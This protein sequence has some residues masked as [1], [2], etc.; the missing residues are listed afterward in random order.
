MAISQ[1][2]TPPTTLHLIGNGFD[3]FH[4][5]DSRYSDFQ[6]W[7]SDNNCYPL[8]TFIEDLCNN[9]EL[10]SNFEQALGK[11]DP[12]S[13]LKD[14]FEEFE[15]N[16]KDNEGDFN[17]GNL[18]STISSDLFCNL[19][20]NYSKLMQ[21]FKDWAKSIDIDNIETTDL[22]K[23]FGID[24]YGAFVTFNYTHTLEN[25]YKI[26]NVFH[27]HGGV[28]K[29][30]GEILVGHGKDFIET[31]NKLEEY[32]DNELFCVSDIRDGIIDLL[33]IGRKSVDNTLKSLEQY[34]SD[35]FGVQPIE[36]I[37]VI[38]HSYG[39]VDMPYFNYLKQQY[40]NATWLL[41]YH[42][43]DTLAK[44]QK[45]ANGIQSYQLKQI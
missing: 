12:V 1:T 29:Q 19:I 27:I 35:N 2:H 14:K 25:A 9:S 13:V 23:E 11:I 20:P 41:Y 33:N 22:S 18:S 26:S 4:C 6:N 37:I 15:E 8:I 42:D 16:G 39:E 44:A 38:G 34:I 7:L 5:I 21:A 43:K 36:K 28:K 17:P 31:R 30:D 45:F 3:L 32:L 10:W 24:V 40:P